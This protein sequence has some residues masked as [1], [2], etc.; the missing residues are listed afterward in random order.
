MNSMKRRTFI[1]SVAAVLTLPANPFLSL[2]P[3]AAA[4]PTAAVVP[5]QARSWAV[6]IST[7]HGECPPQALQ[8]ML[9][10]P[11]VDAKKYVTQLVADGIIKPNPLLQKTVSRFV[12]TD[13]DGLLDKVKKRL[14][15][16]ARAERE[17][18]EVC[19]NSDGV[20]CFDNEAHLLEAPSEVGVEVVRDD[21]TLEAETQMSDDDKIQT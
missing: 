20:K 6:Y 2:Q 11:A 17:E 12:K 13:E 4:V 18:A 10:I 15:M 7:L 8:T 1:Q 14:E 5:A 21:E 9:N 19:K 16:K 3:V